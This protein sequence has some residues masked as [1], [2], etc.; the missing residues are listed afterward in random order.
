M[1]ESSETTLML[2]EPVILTLSVRTRG[3]MHSFSPELGGQLGEQI[4]ITRNGAQTRA[5]KLHIKNADG[6]Y[7]R[8]FSF[9]Y[10]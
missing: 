1:T 8:T 4:E 2:G 7:E 9:E 10:G 5:P 3:A 6:K